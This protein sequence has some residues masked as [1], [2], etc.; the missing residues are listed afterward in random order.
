MFVEHVIDA[1]CGNS[2]YIDFEIRPASLSKN[3]YVLKKSDLGNLIGQRYLN[4][5][6]LEEL[7][8]DK[9][10]HLIGTVIKKR[11]LMKCRLTAKNSICTSCF[12][13]LSYSIHKHTNIGH[14][15]AISASSQ[16]TQAVLN[17]KHIAT[18]AAG[19]S[20]KLD[21][22][23]SSY[24]N[25]KL[26][27]EYSFKASLLGKPNIQLFL[28]MDPDSV[29]G[30][31]NIK[32]KTDVTKL[33]PSRN[34]RISKFIVIKIVR[35]V[36]TIDEIDLNA[37]N[38]YGVFTVEFLQ[39]IAKHQYIVDTNGRYII[40]LKYWIKPSSFISLP[41]VEFS[42]FD[43][44]KAVK[45]LFKSNKNKAY[46][47][48]ETQESLLIKLFDLITAK[49]DIN[50]VVLEVIVYAFTIMSKS[51]FDMGRNSSTMMVTRIFDILTTRSLG[52]GLAWEQENRFINS[53]TV[54]DGRNAYDH[55]LDVLL[56]PEATLL[57]H[58]VDI[59]N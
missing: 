18:S 49:L 29:A 12:G 28:S 46:D 47:S 44:S 21:K 20:F 58:N 2:D 22:I 13:E 32:E 15:T 24:F 56:C 42:F 48:D 31:P 5:N 59:Y 8:T 19:E 14:L 11:S 41:N 7:I 16:V 55:L 39:Y 30:L 40:D 57:D 54:F 3:G 45:A 50:I 38:K 17:A 53:P 27:N 25:S 35:G 10:T 1:D 33:N 34:S 52:G 23:S 36:K 43:L 4:D 37:G 9:H 26:R 6:N 51:N